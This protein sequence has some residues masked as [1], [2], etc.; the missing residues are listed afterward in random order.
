MSAPLESSNTDVVKKEFPAIPRGEAQKMN[1]KL[2]YMAKQGNSQAL[3]SY[4]DDGH[5]LGWRCRSVVRL[6]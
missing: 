6:A 3:Q 1:E 2:N 5:V 4:Q